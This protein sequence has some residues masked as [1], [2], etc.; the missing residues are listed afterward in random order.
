M[1]LSPPRD[2]APL[3]LAALFFAAC[4]GAPERAVLDFVPNQTNQQKVAAYIVL[5][6]KDKNAPIPEWVTRYQTEGIPGVEA[7]S[8]YQDK[9]I[10][11]AENSGSNIN[12]LKQWDSSFQVDLDLPRLVSARVQA[13][14]TLAA[15]ATY[16][17]REFGPFF[18]AA[19]KRSSDIVYD[20]VKEADF[21][22]LRQYSANEAV[23][24]KLYNFL[25]LVLVDKSLL[26]VEIHT[27]LNGI[28]LKPLS[29]DQ[30]DAVDQIKDT[31]FAGF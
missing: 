31:F 15:S 26:Q 16:P 2:L 7:L 3:L 17:D 21:W 23:S 18:E 24:E 22:S 20:G 9:Y 28:D 10:F 14:L 29:D 25:I 30:R 19:V 6:Y 4:A 13:C 12:A 5:D 11:I 8:E 1:M 27:V